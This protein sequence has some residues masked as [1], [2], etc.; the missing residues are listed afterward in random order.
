MGIES[1][2]LYPSTLN[3]GQ[4][5]EITLHSRACFP[6]FRKEDLLIGYSF[7]TEPQHK[8]CSVSFLEHW[9]EQKHL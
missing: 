5:G 2:G 3:C 6:V 9:I 8:T 4:N 1:I 7:H